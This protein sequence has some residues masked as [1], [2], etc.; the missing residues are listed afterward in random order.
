MNDRVLYHHPHERI[1]VYS[2][3]SLEIGNKSDN[4]IVAEN[5]DSSTEIVFKEVVH[6]DGC[7]KVIEDIVMKCTD[8]F[9]FDLCNDCYTTISQEHFSGC[10]KF[11]AEE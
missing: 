7:H 11:I 1:F 6:C 2:G 4:S 9:D 10:H 8:C 3:A 5:D